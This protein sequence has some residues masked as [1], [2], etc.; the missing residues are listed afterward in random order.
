[1]GKTSM[2]GVMFAS[3]AC[4]SAVA[5]PG[6]PAASAQGCSDVEVVF[7]RGT[8]EPAG[9]GWLGT[10]FVNSVRGKVGTKTVSA[11]A[12]DYPADWNLYASVRAGGSNALAH[13]HATAVNCPNTRIVL[14]GF[15]QG[16]GVIDQLAI[17][18]PVGVFT[19]MPLPAEDQ[20]RIAAIAVF[21]NP[22]RTMNNGGSLVEKSPVY[23]S[24]TIDQCAT[25]DKYCD[26]G[27][28]PMAHYAYVQNG[29][30]DQAGAFVAARV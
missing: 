5:G 4:A 3:V 12:V 24:R 29:M 9:V 1:M 11:Y 14:G 25:G 22:L 27:T 8:G 18:Q 6:I 20:P 13:I 2:I 21:G 26:G 28:D 23:G 30:V 10:A 15:S 7:A 16:A 17:G 19:P